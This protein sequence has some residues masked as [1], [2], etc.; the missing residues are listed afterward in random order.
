MFIEIL[1]LALLVAVIL[2]RVLISIKMVTEHAVAYWNQ[3]TL[4]SEI[5][6]TLNPSRSLRKATLRAHSGPLLPLR[7]SA[8][9]Q[10]QKRTM[11][12]F[13]LSRETGVPEVLP[14]EQ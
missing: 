2:V 11:E 12:P 9:I 6:A 13:V 5:S 8:R 14:R 4:I 3:Q 1:F 10:A 7:R